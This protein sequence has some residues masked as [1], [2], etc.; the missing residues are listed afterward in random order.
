MNEL[1]NASTNVNWTNEQIQFYSGHRG[2]FSLAKS[3]WQT[4]LNSDAQNILGELRH[5]EH[6]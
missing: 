5:D 2:R 4:V 6:R 3:K 1:M